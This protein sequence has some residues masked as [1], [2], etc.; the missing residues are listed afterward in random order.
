MVP[1]RSFI[2][3]IL[4]SKYGLDRSNQNKPGGLLHGGRWLNINLGSGSHVSH[5]PLKLPTNF[6]AAGQ[7]LLSTGKQSVSILVKH[8]VNYGELFSTTERYPSAPF[9]LISKSGLFNPT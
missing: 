6:P 1:N 7:S 5:C 2:L 9:I 3:K 8:F 4:N